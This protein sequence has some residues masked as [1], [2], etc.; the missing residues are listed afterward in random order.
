MRQ[1]IDDLSDDAKIVHAS[2]I[3]HPEFATAEA[4]AYGPYGLQQLSPKLVANAL[5]ELEEA[6]QATE[7]FG[8][9]SAV[10]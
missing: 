8:S 9:W 1:P 4:I 3:D 7:R 6:G 2:L 5:R 10:R